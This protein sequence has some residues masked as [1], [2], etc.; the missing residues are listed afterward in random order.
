MKTTSEVTPVSLASNTRGFRLHKE[1]ACIRENNESND[2][3]KVLDT[4]YD[5]TRNIRKRTRN[6]KELA[7]YEKL[8]KQREMSY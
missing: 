4:S 5:T 7:Y 3:N 1:N 8:Y 2:E 6:E